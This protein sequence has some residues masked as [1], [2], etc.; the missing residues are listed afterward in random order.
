MASGESVSPGYFLRSCL[1]STIF[2][3]LT[4]PAVLLGAYQSRFDRDLGHPGW[5]RTDPAAFILTGL[6]VRRANGEFDS[7]E[8]GNPP[9][10]AAMIARLLCRAR[11]PGFRSGPSADA[12]TGD[13]QRQPP[14]VS[15]IVM[16]CRL[17]RRDLCITYWAFKRKLLGG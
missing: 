7:P 10:G 14:N 5:C 2:I 9:R 11:P 12:L 6:Y 1:A 13:V 17:R 3:L 16:F 8:P 4:F 15:A